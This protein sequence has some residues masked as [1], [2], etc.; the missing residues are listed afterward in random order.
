MKKSIVR[1]LY[2][3]PPVF[4]FARKVN[5]S[6][7]WHRNRLG[8]HIRRLMGEKSGFRENVIRVNPNDITMM[9]AKAG[10]GSRDW[11]KQS[12]AIV[13]DETAAD[14][15][16]AICASG[17]HG[18]SPAYM[19]ARA[20]LSAGK[21]VL[22]CACTSELDTEIAKAKALHAGATKLSAHTTEGESPLDARGINIWIGRQGQ[23]LLCDGAIQLGLCKSLGCEDILVT[24][25]HRHPEWERFRL[26]LSVYAK[27]YHG[28]LYQKVHHPDTESFPA[29]HD[30][31][32]RICMILQ[33]LPKDAKTVIDLGADLGA[34]TR[35][36]EDQ[37]YDVTA[38]ER[39]PEV[40]YY[41]RLIRDQ[42]GYK[43][44]IFFGDIRQYCPSKRVDILSALSVLHFFLKTKSDQDSLIK[45]LA[46]LSPR[47]IFF[48]PPLFR[49]YAN[50]GWYRN[51]EPDEFAELVKDWAALNT[52]EKIGIAVGGR[53]V[54][55]IS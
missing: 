41:L 25:G 29:I 47:I 28:R 23:L 1:I 30:C 42:L 18:S 34:M 21:T 11:D 16:Q 3:C 17:D 49:E 4:N 8:F 31:R 12:V 10:D 24:I 5:A 51:Y 27:R 55:R 48:E 13:E 43:H 6:L 35:F 52:I 36:F 44:E 9:L 50:A 20:K 53:P 2:K 46:R 40:R 54:Y 45:L 15:L 37:G 39:D 14:L 32:D 33:H 38:V 22:E 26:E 19:K 7:R